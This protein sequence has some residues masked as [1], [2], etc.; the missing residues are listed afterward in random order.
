MTVRAFVQAKINWPSS[1]RK[2]R[3]C[4]NVTVKLHGCM[5]ETMATETGGGIGKGRLKIMH[6]L[7]VTSKKRE[8]EIDGSLEKHHNLTF[9]ASTLLC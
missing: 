9:M 1:K 4:Y 7:H 5:D 6:K 8:I 3:S 2:T